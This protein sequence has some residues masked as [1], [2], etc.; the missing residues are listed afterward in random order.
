MYLSIPLGRLVSLPP[1]TAG[2]ALP[3]RLDGLLNKFQDDQSLRGIH[4]LLVIFIEAG[5]GDYRAALITFFVLYATA[6]IPLSWSET[7][8]DEVG[9]DLGGV[10]ASAPIPPS[11][12]YRNEQRSGSPTGPGR[13]QILLQSTSAPSKKDSAG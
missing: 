4:W 5:R 2:H 8:G 9:C 3:H 6:G 12:A 7:S 13:S 11:W 1:R 10:R